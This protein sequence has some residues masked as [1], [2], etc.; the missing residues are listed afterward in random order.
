[1][2]KKSLPVILFLITSAA[3]WLTLKTLYPTITPLES[4]GYFFERLLNP[5]IGLKKEVIGFLPYWRIEDIKHI[6]LSHLSEV[7]YFSL[8]VGADGHIVTVVG[9]E[10]DPGYREWNNPEIK[11]LI[12]KSKIFGTKFSVTIAC[13]DNE[14]IKAIL[15]NPDS[16]QNLITDISEQIK[17]RRLDGVNI[18]FEYL[19][20]PDDE[21]RR[22][23]TE[24]S[25]LLSENL[26]REFPE[27]TLSL[28][29]M[30]RA[31]RD[32]DLF[33]FDSLV[34]YY[35]RFIGMSYDYYGAGSDIAG[36]GAPMKG[37]KDNKYF[38]DV[39][40]T[41]EDYLKVIPKHKIIMGIP[42]YGWDWAVEKGKTINSKTLPDSDEN[43][44]AAV[45]SYTRMKTDNNLKTNQCKWDDYALATW[46]WY[47]DDKKVDHQVWLEDERSIGIKYE[48]AKKQD[49]AGAAIWVL[50]YDKN[51]PDLWNK[52]KSIFTR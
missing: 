20:E 44:Y 49:F 9:N 36:P 43:S 8:S 46:C 32:K 34:P 12:A 2:M 52:I 41:Y 10:T 51:H 50:G 13:Q 48:Y 15:A 26:K 38:F 37:F 24:F 16:Q 39:E 4:A 5:P 1:M 6:R 42:H 22:Q 3:F 7:N 27:L 47:T 25:K 40:T 11:N 19:G 35:D 14:I 30:P 31:A 23:F 45:M 29:I 21:Q 28:S 33:I 17:Q 18:D